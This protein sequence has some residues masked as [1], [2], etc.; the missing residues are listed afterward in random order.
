M[1]RTHRS[2]SPIPNIKWSATDV[3]KRDPDV[4]TNRVFGGL[5][6]VI[7]ALDK[8]GTYNRLAASLSRSSS[9]PC[10]STIFG[11]FRTVPKVDGVDR[12]EPDDTSKLPLRPLTQLPKSDDFHLGH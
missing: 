3:L 7:L 11:G 5:W 2:S 8:V 1:N 10:I 12:L 6:I 9:S 4:L